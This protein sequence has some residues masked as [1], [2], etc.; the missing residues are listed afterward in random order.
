MKRLNFNKGLML[1][2][3]QKHKIHIRIR[4]IP[5]AS[6][7]FARS[8]STTAASSSA[9]KRL[10]ATLS[11]CSDPF[12]PSRSKNEFSEL[13]AQKLSPMPPWNDMNCSRGLAKARSASATPTRGS[14]TALSEDTRTLPSQRSTARRFRLRRL[15]S[16]SRSADFCTKQ[17]L[18]FN[19]LFSQV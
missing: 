3:P 18:I 16:V 1:S 10:R 17:W 15:S 2:H 9:P 12:V 7:L 19:L 4:K 6:A 5:T 13:R 14:P 11:H 8:A